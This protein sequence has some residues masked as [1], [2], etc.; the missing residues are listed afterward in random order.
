MT[1]KNVV[2]VG[3]SGS[4]GKIILEGLIAAGGFNITALSRRDSSATFPPDISVYKSDFC[5][6]DLQ[7][8]FKDQGVVISALG[9]T[10]FGEQKKLVDAAIGAGVKHSA[11]L[12]LLPLFSQKSEMI[13][14]LKTKHSAGFSWTGVATSLLFDWG[15]RSGFL[16][17]DIANKTATVWDG[18][19]KSFTLTNERD[20]GIAIA[21]VLKK[22]EETSNKYLFVS[23]VET[24]QNETLAA[25]EEATNTKW[26]INTTTTEEQVND[27]F[28]KLTSGDLNG[29]FALVRATS[30]RNTPGLK[31]NYAQDETLSNDLL[32]LKAS[33][34]AETVKRVVGAL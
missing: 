11:V 1:Y 26:T 8:A 17:Y 30:Y 22:P 29:A 20:L 4:I 10:G 27:A 2:I 15:L 21:S 32:G 12:Q 14:Y 7:S 9:A 25:L 31:S 19:D 5:N 24:T 6:S 28:Q 23:S 34:V 18:G 3:A 16:G 33:S 13:E